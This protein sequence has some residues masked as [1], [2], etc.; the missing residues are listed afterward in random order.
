MPKPVLPLGCICHKCRVLLSQQELDSLSIGT[1]GGRN[2]TGIGMS[3]K[4]RRYH[5]DCTHSRDSGV[6]KI[7]VTIMLSPLSVFEQHCARISIANFFSAK[8]AVKLQL[9]ADAVEM[10][11]GPL[12]DEADV[13]ES[14]E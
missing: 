6:S 5:A 8:K 12:A 4:W 14:E 7:G 3:F 11:D 10:E 2:G 1:M 9:A 13:E